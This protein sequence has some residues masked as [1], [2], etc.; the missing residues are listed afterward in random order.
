MVVHDHATPGG[1]HDSQEIVDAA[2]DHA[3]AHVPLDVRGRPRQIEERRALLDE[4]R[5][6][7]GE[8]GPW[9]SDAKTKRSFSPGSTT[10]ST[11]I[12]PSGEPSTP[13]GS[14][15]DTR[16]SSSSVVRRQPSALTTRAT[17]PSAVQSSVPRLAWRPATIRRGSFSS[18]VRPTYVAG[19][20]R[21][22]S[23]W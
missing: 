5:G 9:T 16:R 19:S 17:G 7:T 22:W 21:K 23:S 15:G 14:G 12:A 6:A 10:V 8:S 2:L 3:R 13:C 4:V 20:E 18:T 11:T 1:P